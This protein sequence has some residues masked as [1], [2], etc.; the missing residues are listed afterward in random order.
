MIAKVNIP[1]D[2]AASMSGCKPGS[3]LTITATLDDMAKDGLEATAT[4]VAKSGG[5]P[6]PL[7]DDE[8][9][10][11]PLPTKKSKMPPMVEADMGY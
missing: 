6:P 11:A 10:E 8:D 9:G 7:P 1:D 4:K 3:V 2:L 5:G